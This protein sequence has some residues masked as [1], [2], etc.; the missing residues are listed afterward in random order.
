MIGHHAQYRPLHQ[1]SMLSLPV[2]VTLGG[3]LILTSPPPH[4]Q[5]LPTTTTEY[6][7]L[8]IYPSYIGLISAI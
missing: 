3:R 1:T 8:Y 5:A 2:S 7:Q 6:D 4:L